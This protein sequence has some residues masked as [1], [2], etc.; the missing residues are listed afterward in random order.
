MKKISFVAVTAMAALT[1]MSCGG[2]A[3]KASLKSD[4]DTLSYAMGIL[5]SQGLKPFLSERMSVDTAYMADFMKGLA[6]GINGSDNKKKAAY[7]AGLQIASQINSQ[8]IPGINYQVFGDDSTATI[9][10]QNLLAGFAASL[11]GKDTTMTTE[12]ADSLV[13][14]LM[15]SIKASH[16]EVRFAETKKKGE[17]FMAENAKKEGVQTTESGLQYKVLK[18]GTGVVPT[19]TSMVKVHYEG[20]LIDGTVFD[21]SIERGNP[22]DFRVNQMIPGFTEALKLMPAGS[23]W[24]VYIPQELGYGAQ[25]SGKID[26]FSALIFKIQLLEVKK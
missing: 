16:N 9:S 11:M 18:A 10:K 13:R 4:V 5:Q 12:V 6:E 15:E 2:N 26:P 19:D 23:E 7:M 25:A 14:T 1:M 3:P 21:S 24:E 20:K 22:A 8:M 17:D